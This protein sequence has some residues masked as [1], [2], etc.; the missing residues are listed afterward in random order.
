MLTK[1]EYADILRT[2]EPVETAAKAILDKIAELNLTPTADINQLKEEYKTLLFSKLVAVDKGIK[3]QYEIH[4]TD[5]AKLD[6]INRTV[7]LDGYEEIAE[8]E[9]LMKIYFGSIPYYFKNKGITAEDFLTKYSG[10]IEATFSKLVIDVTDTELYKELKAVADTLNSLF[11]RGVI[12]KYAFSNGFYYILQRFLPA[13]GFT[14]T[15][16]VDES[17]IF[18]YLRRKN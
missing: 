9:K 6:L 15:V 10:S 3:M 5:K 17:T 16:E 2:K 18:Y 14:K 4:K 13:N 11:E 8:L 1:R 12:D 7:S